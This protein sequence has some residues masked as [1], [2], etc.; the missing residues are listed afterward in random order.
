MKI[1]KNPK[2]IDKI[3]QNSVIAIGNFDG[4]HLGHQTIFNEGKK[5][6]SKTN[7]KF[8]VLSFEPHP[9][10]LFTPSLSPFRITPEESKIRRIKEC[11]TDFM[12]I[13]KFDHD[14][15]KM[16]PSYFIENILKNTIKCEHIIVG[17][18]FHFGHNRGGN[19]ES[20]KQAGFNVTALEKIS[21]EE[22]E[23]YSSTRIREEIRSGNMRAA[24]E[25]LGWEW[26]IEGEVIHGD[27]RGRE[28]G[29]PTANVE[30]GNNLHPSY[31]VYGCM[32]KIEGED[33]WRKAAVN[34][35]IRPMFETKTALVESYIFDFDQEIYGKTLRIKPI[36]KIR[37]EMKFDSLDELV[38]QIRQDCDLIRKI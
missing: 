33:N 37:N 5:I 35:G 32:V 26:E 17:N 34:I 10:L 23:T 36:R 22:D 9:K 31:G 18:D 12:I 29:Y 16:P 6:A 20:L 21:D 1:Y 25:I 4:V 13:Y 24:D 14:F 7:K 11:D 3:H 28:L 8:G 30:L 15:A 38:D 27:K 2:K 19:I